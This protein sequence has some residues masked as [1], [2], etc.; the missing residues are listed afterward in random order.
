M[1][2]A[3][4]NKQ[5]E[6]NQLSRL[7]W[8]LIFFSF[9][10]S[11]AGGFSYYISLYLDQK[12]NFDPVQIGTIGSF[13]GLGGLVG[14][15]AAATIADKIKAQVTILFSLF[16]AGLA[17]VSVPAAN[18]VSH[19]A[20]CVFFMGFSSSI[21]LTANN[22]FLLKSVGQ[23]E[24]SLRYAQNLKAWA[25]NSGN[26]VS[27]LLIM[28]LAGQ[29]FHDIF[30]G[31]G[32]IFVLFSVTTLKLLSLPEEKN[33]QKDCVTKKEI[34]TDNTEKANLFAI[35]FCVFLVGIIFAQQKTIY[36][37]FLNK[38]IGSNFLIGFLLW[39]DPILVIIFQLKVNEIFKN[40]DGYLMMGIGSLLLGGALSALNF[41]HNIYGIIG[42]CFLWVLGEMIFM[43]ISQVLC[44]QQGSLARKGLSLGAWRIAY[45][46]SLVAG[47]YLSGV[48]L[49][50]YGFYANWFCSL[51]LGISVATISMGIFYYNKKIKK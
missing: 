41:V 30:Y 50:R 37:L 22:A 18:S 35:T 47:P 10:E 14:A 25:E 31:I 20:V 12:T 7:T 38:E 13:M 26:S 40:I 43:P 27:M 28:F 34:T 48:L 1:Y 44:F 33:I 23:E 19:M 29:A 2:A 6:Q 24:G 11:A 39:L 49:D 46:C 8:T 51:S 45:S 17:Y 42:V 16:L 3:L 32:L 5:Q 15:V 21:F 36:P 9:I 4:S